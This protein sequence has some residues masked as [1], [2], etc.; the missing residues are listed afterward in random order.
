[1][2]AIAQRLAAELSALSR[3]P[4]DLNTA[5]EA[6]HIAG[7]LQHP[8]LEKVFGDYSDFHA[9]GAGGS[10]VILSARYGPGDTDRA[11]KLP[12]LKIVDPASTEKPHPVLD[13]ERHALSKVSHKHI[14]RLFEAD[15][16]PGRHA[17]YMITELVA[18]HLPLDRYALEKCG[19]VECRRDPVKRET[20]LRRCKEI[21]A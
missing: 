20:A 11:I 17:Y 14:T 2:D 16:L 12:R 18:S 1:M 3:R 19:S 13:P 5:D 4:E 10:N 21:T 15:R 6:A 9:I 8:D 7:V